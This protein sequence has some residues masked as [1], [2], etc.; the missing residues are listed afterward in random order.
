MLLAS[1]LLVSDGPF[2]PVFVIEYA[3][4][5]RRVAFALAVLRIDGEVKAE[6]GDVR[7][8]YSKEALVGVA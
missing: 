4:E 5:H 2:G 7:F 8:R 6:C 3:T 1:I